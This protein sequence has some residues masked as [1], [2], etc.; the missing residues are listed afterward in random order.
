[1]THF[2]KA[3]V[4]GGSHHNTLGVIR[5]LGRKGINPDVIITRNDPSSFVLKSKYIN[6]RWTIDSSEAAIDLLLSEYSNEREKPVVY[7]CHDVIASI[8][9][10][11]YDRLSPYFIIPGISMQGQVTEYMNKEIMGGLASSAGLKVPRSWIIN[12]DSLLQQKQ[13]V[14]FPCITKPLESRNGNKGEIMVCNNFDQLKHFLKVKKGKDYLVQEYVD[15]DFEFQLI[16]CSLRSGEEVVIP[17]VSTILRQPSNTNTGFL[18]YGLCDKSYTQTIGN[19]IVFIREIG[20]SGL[21]SAEFLRDKNGGDYFMEINFRNDGN[22][23]AVTNAGVNLP[24]IWYLASQNIDY[25]SEITP[26]HDEYV[27]PEFDEMSLYIHGDISLSEWK[28]DMERATSYM[29][30]DAEDPK[31]TDSWRIY[32]RQKRTATIKRIAYRVLKMLKVKN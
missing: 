28:N 19:T 12:Y 25:R 18:H 8:I 22:S 4:I 1:M 32:N 9:D 23:I 3:I 7:T 6:R 17:G 21:F 20:Y 11:N 2:S 26:L 24:Y 13:I 29:D 27:M 16:G 10:L 14:V 31:P 5:S 30:F 15:K